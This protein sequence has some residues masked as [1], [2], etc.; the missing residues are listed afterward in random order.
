MFAHTYA[1][2]ACGIGVAAG[3]S[4]STARGRRLRQR[5]FGWVRP[6]A[7]RDSF[8]AVDAATLDW[9]S[10]QA[11]QDLLTYHMKRLFTDPSSGS[12]VMLV[13]YPA[14]EINP[15]HTHSVGHGMYV[16]QGSLVTSR[17]TFG[18]GAFVWFPAGEVMWHGAGSDAPLEML[19]MVGEGMRTDYVDSAGPMGAA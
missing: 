19:F 12:T 11:H 3:M 7:G 10:N 9:V 15:S 13:R 16:L 2:F 8:T 5:L 4:A 14:G 18:P 1:V 17:G 6:M